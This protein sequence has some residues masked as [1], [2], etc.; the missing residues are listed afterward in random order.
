M[1][2]ALPLF[3]LS[4]RINPNGGLFLVK[5]DRPFSAFEAAR[6][7]ARVMK[8][9]GLY[10]TKPFVPEVS[11]KII[12]LSKCRISIFLKMPPKPNDKAENGTKNKQF[13]K[14]FFSSL[15]KHALL[16]IQTI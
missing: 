7:S 11:D 3:P 1:V 4:R 2:R 16:T 12:E 10:L 9:A 8:R 6:R 14:L 13:G 5:R 15:D